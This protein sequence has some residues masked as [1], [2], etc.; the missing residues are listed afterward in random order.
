MLT[1]NSININEFLSFEFTRLMIISY[2]ICGFVYV[3]WATNLSFIALKFPAII[4]N[5]GLL[6]PIYKTI[7]RE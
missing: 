1:K 6:K 2:C 3:S 5:I 7:L 4:S